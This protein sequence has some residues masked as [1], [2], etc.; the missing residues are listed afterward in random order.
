MDGVLTNQASVGYLTSKGI[1]VVGTEGSGELVYQ[2]PTYFPQASSGLY[3]LE[4]PIYAARDYLK[5][6]GI[7]KVGMISCIEAAQ[8]GTARSNFKAW[9]TQAGF[10]PVFSGQA[11]LATADFTSQCQQAQSAGAQAI[12]TEMDASSNDR[13][14][15]S[16]DSVGYHPHLVTN[17]QAA[18]QNSL[19]DPLLNG[20]LLGVQ[21]EPPVVTGS[22]AVDEMKSA[23]ARYA[24]GTVVDTNVMIGWTAA[25]LFEAATKNLAEPPTSASV[26][27]GLW[28]LKNN[29]LGGL[30]YRL[31]F[32]RG[33]DAP[34]VFCYWLMMIKNGQYVSP[35]N[36]ARACV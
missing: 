10:D 30:T 5:P 24:P 26:L 17:A 15:R 28:S 36:G 9:A 7:T 3:L 18:T 20:F 35:N 21:V 33:Q 8:C 19:Q 34:H 16:C 4:Q 31:T 29:D 13:I 12:F 11:S 2:N 23:M 27:D 32:T 22:A 6:Q 25:K 14:A 1:P